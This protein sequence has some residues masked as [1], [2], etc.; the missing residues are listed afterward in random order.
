M[1]KH[2]YFRRDDETPYFPETAPIPALSPSGVALYHSAF[3]TQQK[4]QLK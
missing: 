1:T 2:A 4:D 3:S